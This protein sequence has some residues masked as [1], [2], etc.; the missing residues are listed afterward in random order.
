VFAAVYVHKKFN[1]M[2]TQRQLDAAK[3]RLKMNLIGRGQFILHTDAE[4][5]WLRV[6]FRVLEDV[7]LIDQ[8]SGR[9]FRT[10]ILAYLEE[11]VDAP[12]FVRAYLKAIDKDEND[13]SSFPYFVKDDGIESPVRSFRRY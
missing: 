10:A 6:P 5:A 3:H 4:H 7:G 8:I 2:A 13:L 12:L 1:I 9:S 11:D